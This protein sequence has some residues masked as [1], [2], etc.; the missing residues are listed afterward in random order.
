MENFLKQFPRSPLRNKYPELHLKNEAA[1]SLEVLDRLYDRG[2]I[3]LE[4]YLRIQEEILG[5]IDIS[6]DLPKDV[7]KSKQK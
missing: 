7:T 5:W 6:E 4:N 1:E 3:S 2:K